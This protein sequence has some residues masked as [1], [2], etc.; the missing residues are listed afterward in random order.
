M[1]EENLQ[2]RV[3]AAL[4]LG[5]TP[6]RSGSAGDG[7]TTSMDMLMDVT[8]HLTV[9]LGRANMSVGQ[10][11]DLQKGSVIELN[12]I[13]GEAVD[14]YVN[15]RLLARGDVVVVDDKFGVRITEMISPSAKKGESA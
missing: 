13:A 11:L 15:N 1:A 3:D 5:N 9:E 8:L 12:R 7:P 10:V 14:I 2:A 6:A 4:G